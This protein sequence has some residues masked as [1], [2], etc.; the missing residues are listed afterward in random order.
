MQI[1]T[2]LVI[3][4]LVIG[5]VYGFYLVFKGESG[6]FGFFINA[7]LGPIFLVKIYIGVRK[8]MKKMQEPGL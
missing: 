3:I 6:F 5:A 7:L 8:A 4:Y 2:V 1:L